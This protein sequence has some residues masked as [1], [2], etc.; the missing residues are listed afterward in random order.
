MKDVLETI[1][2]N[3]EPIIL[4]LG[5]NVWDVSFEKEGKNNF[6]RVYIFKISGESITLDDC[7]LVSANISQVLDKLD[8]IENRYYLEVSSVGLN[9]KL[10]K[11]NHFLNSI[12]KKVFLK[13]KK[14]FEGKKNLK[15]I[16]KEFKNGKLT[17]ETKDE[18]FYVELKNCLYVKL[19]DELKMV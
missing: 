13:F 11:E 2:K 10:V 9:R 5:L 8:L 7:E 14:T 16:L 17:L 18:M 15:G 3:I 12:G 1:R 6:L 4:E 19:E